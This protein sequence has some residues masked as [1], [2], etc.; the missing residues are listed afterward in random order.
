MSTIKVSDPTYSL[1]YWT[2]DENRKAL[3]K[4]E[5]EPDE[6]RLASQSIS[7]KGAK[8][9]PFVQNTTEK[10]CR[11][12]LFNL[13]EK[14]CSGVN[15]KITFSV[16]KGL[17]I[18]SC[19]EP[20]FS[21]YVNELIS[22]FQAVMP[23]SQ[24]RD[25][26][27]RKVRRVS[28]SKENL[29]QA[30]EQFGSLPLVFFDVLAYQMLRHGVQRPQRINLSFRCQ[31]FGSKGRGLTTGPLRWAH[32]YQDIWTKI[33]KDVRE[34]ADTS[35]CLVGPGLEDHLE[36]TMPSCCQFAELRTLFPKAQC[37]LL[38]N[39]P[40]LITALS[41]QL[42]KGFTIYDPTSLIMRSILPKMIAP[43]HYQPLLL[44]MRQ[45]MAANSVLP[46]AQQM[47]KGVA[48][49]K[50]LLLKT[51]AKPVEI[52]EFDIN[53]SAF[54][55]SESKSFDVM[56]ATLSIVNAMMAAFEKDKSYDQ[57]PVFVKFLAALKETGTLYI[58]LLLSEIMFGH[59]KV[60][61]KDEPAL[62]YLEALLG[63]R[64]S[65]R[66]IPIT[67]FLPSTQGDMTTL[68]VV[69]CQGKH[70]S[71][72]VPTQSAFAITRIGEKVE[73]SSEELKVLRSKL[74]GSE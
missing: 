50:P 35:L 30:R 49:I 24:A 73:A 23:A 42:G 64:L 33:P 9:H 70:L 51:S 43:K 65:I 63:S 57:A 8:I 40:K 31:R 25:L 56:V 28:P 39:S 32:I 71:S 27:A 37:L 67:D 17:E 60:P 5:N 1:I 46:G 18:Q 45:V 36:K 66:K 69:S 22:G 59:D 15:A 74:Y 7:P 19:T 26:V 54:K 3:L 48:P 52:R 41:D 13:G 38:D 29:Q 21:H 16:Q 20:G 44:A 62:Q 53:T 58:D 47:L 61:K 34:S 68:D 14:F 55:E 11:D 72:T 6:L 2:H 12:Y 10:L 4:P